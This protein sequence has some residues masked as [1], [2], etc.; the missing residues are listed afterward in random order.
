MC[1]KEILMVE[2]RK[3]FGWAVFAIITS[4]LAI[5]LEG[6]GG[7]LAG[8]VFDP[9]AEKSTLIAYL[10]VPAMVAWNEWI[11][12]RAGMTRLEKWGREKVLALSIAGTIVALTILTIVCVMLAPVFFFSIIALVFGI[13]ILGLSPLTDVTV[14]S[15]Q[16]H[17]LLRLWHEQDVSSTRHRQVA[18]GAVGLAG[19]TLFWMV[20]RPVMMGIW[21]RH[22]IT[23]TGKTQQ[24]AL[25]KLR[26]LHG[27]QALQDLAYARQQGYNGNGLGYWFYV[28]F[29]SPEYGL[30]PF[31][32]WGGNFFGHQGKYIDWW[33]MPAK[34]RHAYFLLTGTPFEMGAKPFTARRETLFRLGQPTNA[35]IEEQGGA[36]IGR[37]VEGL[38]LLSIEKTER[39][40]DGAKVYDWILTFKN[41]SN[42]PQEARAELFLPAN[43]TVHKVALWMNG[44][45]VPAKYGYASAARA[46]YENVVKVQ[47]RDP[48]LVSM[49]SP[50]FMQF[51]CYPVP[52]NGGT[53]K[54]R[55]GIL[56]PDERGTRLEKPYFGH[57]NFGIPTEYQSLLTP[58]PFCAPN[59]GLA[60]RVGIVVDASVGVNSK[61]AHHPLIASLAKDSD[62]KTTFSLYTTDETLKVT[63][64][65]TALLVS[66][67]RKEMERQQFRGGTD[68]GKTLSLALKENDTVLF[69]HAA[70]PE[71]GLDLEPV[72]QVLKAS[73]NKILLDVMVQENASNGVLRTLGGFG[74]YQR[75]SPAESLGDTL[76]RTYL[77]SS[78]KDW[79][80]DMTKGSQIPVRLSTTGDYEYTT[81]MTTMAFYTA[82][83]SSD[84]DAHK[85]RTHWGKAAADAKIVTP[86]SS[87]IVMEKNEDYG[88][89]DDPNRKPADPVQSLP[90]PGTLVLLAMGTS[91]LGWV[92][93]RKTLRVN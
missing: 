47:R 30:E 2:S 39:L 59:S 57:V 1:Q 37:E 9:I 56:A 22:A 54:M 36:F 42:Q 63:K 11:L 65:N 17:T 84:A 14:L 27:E 62:Q 35:T 86:F 20:V 31:T 53:M 16:F 58:S 66:S 15:V 28:G 7:V 13:G 18:W 6:F 80:M 43:A 71:Q 88:N 79:N 3:R 55:L 83:S 40:T 19:V 41:D 4:L 24:N 64:I 44:K 5:M 90:E 12:Q 93:R 49:P 74:T 34:A 85:I 77:L 82:N 72:R 21:T 50:G 75:V 48:L 38:R 91:I 29:A 51:Q 46:A 61:L 10:F 92:K 87:A 32:P 78:S 69:F 26:F 81:M 8:E 68:P 60:G 89:L 45:E 33:G 73:T 76:G 25:T 52:A 70:M 23:S 67:W